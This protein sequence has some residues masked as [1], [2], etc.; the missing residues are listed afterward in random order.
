CSATESIEPP[1][2]R[3]KR[4]SEAFTDRPGP[5]GRTQPRLTCALPSLVTRA[6]LLRGR[7]RQ[8]GRCDIDRLRICL[9]R[10]A[11]E[12][13]QFRVVPVR[14][15]ALPLNLTTRPTHYKRAPL[16]G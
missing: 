2:S 12:L 11:F 3:R 4:R 9:T 10:Q 5:R 6:Y 15:R 14:R 8:R 1:T 16:P 13:G 7:S